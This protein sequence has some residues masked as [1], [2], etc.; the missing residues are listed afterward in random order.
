MS[1]SRENFRFFAIIDGASIA[2]EDQ[3][4]DPEY[5]LYSRPGGEWVILKHNIA[6]GTYKYFRG[7]DV[8]SNAFAHSTLTTMET[9]WTNRATLE[10]RDAGFFKAL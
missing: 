6:N 2:K 7:V 5:F 8:P 1:N 4:S 9:A 3:S 10:Y